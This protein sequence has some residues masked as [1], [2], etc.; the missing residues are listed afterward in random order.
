MI[1]LK[2]NTTSFGFSLSHPGIDQIADFE[3]SCVTYV[4]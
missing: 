3:Q 4:K 1:V 2:T